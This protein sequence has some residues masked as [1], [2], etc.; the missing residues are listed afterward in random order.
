MHFEIIEKDWYKRRV[1]SQSL[2]AVSVKID[3]FQKVPNH[4]CDMEVT[5]EDGSKKV[6]KSRVIYNALQQRWTVD[7]MAVAVRLVD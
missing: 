5:Y 4:F 3:D 6:L 7:G 1:P 2:K